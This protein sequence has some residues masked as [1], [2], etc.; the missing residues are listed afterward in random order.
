MKNPGA[1]YCYGCNPGPRGAPACLRCGSCEDYYSAGLCTRC[2]PGAPRRRLDSC[3]DCQAWGALRRDK[4]LCEGCRTWRRKHPQVSACLGCRRQLAVDTEGICRPC[5][6]ELL[7]LP[8]EQRHDIAAAVANG[9]Q[10][11]FVGMLRSSSRPARQPRD[12]RAGAQPRKPWRTQPV[13]LAAFDIAV[14]VKARKQVRLCKTCGI[15][16]VRIA[17]SNYCYPCS[18]IVAPTPP[19]CRRC[20]TTQDY[21]TAGVC[22][23][24]HRLSP[25][26]VDSC[27]DCLAWGA[28]R[29]NNWLCRGCRSWRSN[30]P[31]IAACRHCQRQQHLDADGICRLCRK[32]ISMQ[33]TR[34]RQDP[35][36]MIGRGQQLFFADMF[37]GM[38]AT[39]Q[40]DAERR[41]RNRARNTMPAVTH[42][43]PAADLGTSVVSITEIP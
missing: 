36:K 15:R 29:G 39:K 19:P 4:W 17:Q 24:C 34:N 26:Q 14:P 20:G 43:R 22:I 32:Q 7:R 3:V 42:Y 40:A 31:G 25:I 23:R 6:R 18:P 21:Y 11:I 9:H 35:A 37:L 38:G 33:H 5:H 30:H 27:T 13:Q 16:P 1:W 8:P 10:L 2:H 28:R 41:R 12:S